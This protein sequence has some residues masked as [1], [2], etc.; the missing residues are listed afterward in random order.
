MIL[1]VRCCCTPKKLRGW[2]AVPHTVRTGDII[3]FRILGKLPIHVGIYCE[4]APAA[5][6]IEMKA[7][8]YQDAGGPIRLA[9]KSEDIPIEK[10]KR[11]HGFIEAD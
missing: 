6:I 8:N 1:E 5:E 4:M 7:E 11:I 10:L 3:R 9:L 2:I